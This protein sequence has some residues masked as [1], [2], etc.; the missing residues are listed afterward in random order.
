MR[1]NKEKFQIYVLKYTLKRNADLLSIEEGQFYYVLIKD[2]RT[3]IYN[4]ALHC[5]RKHICHYY[6]QSFSTA[7]ILERHVNDCFEINGE[8]MLEMAK[9][10][11]AVKF[12]NL[13]RKIKL[14]FMIY[15]NFESVLIP[16]K[17]MESEIQ[18]ILVHLNI[19][20]VLIAAII[21]N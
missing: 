15:A 4:Q 3:L 14:P 2:F 10:G 7:Q 11:A 13:T 21:T 16:E 19:K 12:N 6:K 20:I 5:D 9:K 8:Q 17:K 18:M 1:K